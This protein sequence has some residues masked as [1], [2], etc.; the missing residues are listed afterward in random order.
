MQKTAAFSRGIKILIGTPVHESKNYGMERWLNS[1]SK[2]DYPFDLLLV[3]NS[4]N[5]EYA[6]QLHKYCKKIGL[7]NYHLIRANVARGSPLDERLSVCREIIRQ[8]VLKGNYDYWC[9]LECDVIVPPDSLTKLI[10]LTHDYWMVSHAYPAR[11]N[12]SQ[13]NAEFGVA[14][15]KRKCLKSLGFL[16]EYGYIDSFVPKSWQGNDVWFIKRIGRQNRG[17]YIHVYGIIKPIYHLNK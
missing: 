13:T 14:L 3:D 4:D 6:K 15:I 9:S 12:S 2:L 5:P 16:G 8:E 10:D 17:K 1:V 11:N 7:N